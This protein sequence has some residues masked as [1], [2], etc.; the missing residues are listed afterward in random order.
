M[1]SSC[2]AQLQ[3]LE[4]RLF[5][6]ADAPLHLQI[7]EQFHVAIPS[8]EDLKGS[9]GASSVLLVP[10]LVPK[11]LDDSQKQRMG[12]MLTATTQAA[13]GNLLA[14][15]SQSNQHLKQR[16]CFELLPVP[17][18]FVGGLFC[19]LYGLAG[20]SVL[21]HWR[22]GFMIDIR[23]GAC[24]SHFPSCVSLRPSSVAVT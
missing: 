18:S 1:N 10:S 20:V 16:M 24:S 12:Y 9:S 21:F 3:V 5:P 22:T 13:S 19:R 6:T 14:A 7:L 17:F 8:K 23:S 4:P 15:A 11:K 2:L